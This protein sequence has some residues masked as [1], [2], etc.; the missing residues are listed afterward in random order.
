MSPTLFLT[1][2]GLYVTAMI[3]M[4]VWIA[5]RQR[6]GEDFL[7]GNRS[8]PL[9]LSFGT[10]VATLVGTGS[11]IGAVGQGY[12]Y[13][14]RGA[15][16]GIGGGIGM[17][18]L[19]G[20]FSDA[21]RHN[22]MTMAEEVAFYYGANRWMKGLVAI[23]ILFASI[24][25][26]GAHILG[27]SK[28]LAYIGLMDPWLA[29]LVLASGFSVYV[30]I[31]GYV[32][33]VWTDTIQAVVLFFGFILMAF[34]AVSEVGGL[35]ELGSLTGTQLDFLRG[36]K[37]LPSISLMVAIAI[38]VLGVPSFRQRI[39]SADSV[40][41]VRKTFYL[42]T[43]LYFL[44]C[45][46]PA[47]IGICAFHLNP[48]LEEHDHAFL[49][50]SRDVL[51]LSIGL[52][53]LLAGLSATMSSASSDA[54]AAV[55]VL[56]RD[57]YLMFTGKVPS[58]K[59]VIRYT[60]WGL[61]GITGAALA[62]VLPRDDIIDYIKD[63]IAFVL[64]GLVVASIMGKFWPRAT[65]QGGIAAISGG[66]VCTIAFK[67]NPAWDAFWGG[68]TIPSVISATLAGIV[69]SLVTPPNQISEEEALRLLHDERQAMETTQEQVVSES[70]AD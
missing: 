58:P 39:Y 46:V 49:Y 41:T 19:A 2:F 22:F 60:R 29:K 15:M 9:F 56:L 42:T 28:Y 38:G 51:P 32:A 7:L 1:V 35:S 33:V 20:L 68:A 66:A 25:W 37:L 62:V 57:I 24:G 3:V 52:V 36:D 44:F 31:G 34:F 5:R 26:L 64:S 4:S 17:L 63:M 47:I 61:V 70:V 53:V 8:I 65:W 12:G 10:T 48:N 45:F 23:F 11:T 6:S 18:L 50:M 69:V 21:R 67:F 54:I 59:S 14:W 40:S 55:S 13:G 27:G 16:Y 30:I 43:V